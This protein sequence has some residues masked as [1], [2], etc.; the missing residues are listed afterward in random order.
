MNPR[1]LIL[2]GAVSLLIPVSSAIAVTKTHSAPMIA[3]GSQNQPPAGDGDPGDGFPPP[4]PGGGR[5]ERGGNGEP[6]WT[7]DIN[8]SSEQKERIKKLHEQ[9]KKDTESLRSQLMAA[10]QKMRSLF[11]SDASPEQLRKQHQTIQG[12]RQKLDNK[13]FEVMLAERQVLTAQQRS[14]LGKLQQQRQGRKPQSQPR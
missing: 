8:L 11:A 14:Q 6:P 7:K 10:D 9:A 5:G 12:L 4:P 13:R 2:I 1:N 3:Q